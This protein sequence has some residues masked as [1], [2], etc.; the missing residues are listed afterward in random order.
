MTT[1][2]EKLREKIKNDTRPLSV[3]VYM[4]S[5]NHEKYLDKAI[6]GVLM[7][8]TD[9]PVSIVIHDDASTDGSA[10]IIRRYAADNPNIIAILEQ[11]N[12]YQN[13][14]SFLPIVLPYLTGR[15]IAYCECDDFW[16]DEN[17]L[18]RQVDYLEGNPDCS[19]V[20]AASL[21]VNKFGEYDESAR[22]LPKMGEGNYPV[23]DGFFF[24]LHHKHQLATLAA[25]NLYVHLDEEELGFF[26]NYSATGDSKLFRL[27][28][29]LGRVHYFREY[30][31]AYRYVTDSGISYSARMM[32]LNRYDGM[33]Y[34]VRHNLALYDF[35]EFFSGK[36][37]PV[38]WFQSLYYELKAQILDHKSIAKE[39]G[40]K[41]FFRDIPAYVYLTFPIFFICYVPYRIW[42]KITLRLNRLMNSS[43]RELQSRIQ[44]I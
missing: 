25:R 35:I 27:F 16:I 15:Y 38:K 5:Y 30:L 18:Q 6:R 14:R 28:I 8:K 29:M 2:A 12:F 37:H 22:V 13:G 21:P 36:A 19:A 42:G 31:A 1:R 23:H 33:K 40:L 39:L 17:K 32:Q 44:N 10:Q 11:T 41:S 4:T 20:Y 24:R 3:T 9:F 26:M 43:C 7:Q 34:C